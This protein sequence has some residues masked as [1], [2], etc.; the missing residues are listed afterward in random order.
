MKELTTLQKKIMR[1]LDDHEME[2]VVHT[3]LIPPAS[4][5]AYISRYL[6][7]YRE[8]GWIR[9]FVSKGGRKYKVLL[10]KGLYE[11]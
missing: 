10:D 3:D 1:Y 7:E 6:R 5:Q 4:S 8:R 11:V 9:M 2:Y